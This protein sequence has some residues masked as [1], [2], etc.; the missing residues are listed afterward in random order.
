MALIGAD[1]KGRRHVGN[2]IAR[3][4]VGAALGLRPRHMKEARGQ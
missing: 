4:G 1:D 3:T 2:G